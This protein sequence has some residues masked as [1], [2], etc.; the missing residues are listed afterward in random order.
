MN[1][2][3]KYNQPAPSNSPKGGELCRLRFFAISS[4]LH[5]SKASPLGRFGGAF[6]FLLFSFSISAQEIDR[7]FLINKNLSIFSNVMRELDLFYVDTLDYT[8][9]TQIAIDNMLR[10]L[11]PYTV[12][13][14]E[15]DAETITMMTRGQYGGIGALITRIGENVF[16]SEPYEGMPAH[17]YGLRAGDIILEVDGTS[18][19]GL[20]VGEV[21]SMLRGTPS[22]RINVTVRRLG[23]ENPIE[24][25]FLRERIQLPPITFS[26]VLDG[27]IGFVQLSDF[28]NRAAIELKTRVSEMVRNYGIESLIIDVR[29]NTGGLIDEAVQILGFFVPKGTEVVTTRGRS[30]ISDRI[31][32]TPT[33]PDFPDMRLAVLV[34]QNSASASE[35]LAGAIQDLDRGVIIGER[36]FGKGL[37]Q[38][39]RPIVYGGHLKVTVA[40]YYIPSGRSIQAVDHSLRD[41]DGRVSRIPD[42]LTNV[43]HT[44]NGREV[45]DGGGI[46][47]DTVTTAERRMNVAY[48]ILIQNLYFKFANQFVFENPVIAPPSEFELSDEIFDVFVAFLMERNFTFTTQTARF[49]ND[50]EELAQFEGLQERA[51]AEFEALRQRLVPDIL[52]DI[53][54]HR[55][56][57]SDLL[58]IEILKRYYFQQGAV[59]FSLRNDNDLNAAFEILKSEEMYRRILRK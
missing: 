43:F 30:R 3:K 57:I 12:F 4:F 9:L 36:T 47:P 13:M 40:R 42:H 54:N 55:Q 45:R 18:T 33:E 44:R 8:E 51:S 49:L 32:R 50:L 53:E 22:T 37:V 52:Q 41:E 1:N 14:P 38:S 23:V 6:L 19:S 11:D 21:S 58:S 15:E 2:E 56:A 59:E 29:N 31:Y 27:N 5:F 48:H 10:T 34:N 25:T 26:A 7:T 39:V 46:M 16:I 17:R 28:T 24:K 20:S 35:I